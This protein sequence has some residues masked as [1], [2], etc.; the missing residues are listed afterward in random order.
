MRHRYVLLLVI[1]LVGTVGFMLLLSQ[2]MT[3]DFEL[4]PDDVTVV[5][6]LTGA[7]SINQTD[8]RYNVGGTDLGIIWDAGH[9][10]VMLTFGDT[11]SDVRSGAGGGPGSTDWRSNVLALSSDHNMADGL[12]ID[13]MIE[14]VPGHARELLAAKKINFDE[15][16]VIPTAGISV[17]DRQYIHYMSVNNWGAPGV[18][19]TNYAGI[20]FSDDRGQS[21]TKDPNTRW[22]NSA[23]WSNKFQMAAFVKA[24]GYVYMVATPNGRFGPAYLARVPEARVLSKP[25]YQYW[26]G[27]AWHSGDEASAVPIVEAPVAELSVQYNTHFDRWLMLYF[28]AN[29]YA[30]VLRDAKRITGPWSDEK[31][32]ATGI[33][34]PQLYGGYI[35]PW[36]NDGADLY[37]TMSQWQPYNV[38]L[39]KTH[40]AKVG[41]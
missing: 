8:S 19:S 24:D 22:T 39:I 16:T 18:W 17:G 12:Q 37:F 33:D 29:R 11:F 35:H 21:W 14:D 40:L 41:Q 1:G 10:Q 27:Q 2:R 4:Q 32:V 26:D 9:D 3:S 13:A 30:I 23:D 7:D 31:V 28:D 20:A 15:I 36:F 38:F 5:A 6:K 25:D 34:Y